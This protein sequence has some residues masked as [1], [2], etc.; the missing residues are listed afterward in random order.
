MYPGALPDFRDSHLSLY[1]AVRHQFRANRNVIGEDLDSYVNLGFEALR[2]VNERRNQLLNPNWTPKPE[3]V[4]F[5]VGDIVAHRKL[6]V[7]DTCLAWR[8]GVVGLCA[9]AVPSCDIRLGH[10]MCRK[11]DGEYKG[12]TPRTEEWPQA[13]VLLM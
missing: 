8:Y 9:L 13:T 12:L 5:S 7:S 2:R 3:N 4:K 6:A 1:D 11:G 10:G